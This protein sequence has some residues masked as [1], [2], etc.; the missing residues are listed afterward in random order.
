[1]LVKKVLAEMKRFNTPDEVRNFPLGK[2]ELVN[3]G[4]ATIGRATFEPGGAGPRR[5][6]PC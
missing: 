2:L 5:S 1:M 3:I 6:N 4:G